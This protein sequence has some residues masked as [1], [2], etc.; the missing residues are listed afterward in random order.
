MTIDDD[1]APPPGAE[2]EE[3]FIGARPGTP[4]GSPFSH[5]RILSFVCS[6]LLLAAQRGVLCAAER[7]SV[8]PCDRNGLS[9]RSRS[10]RALRPAPGQHLSVGRPVPP[11][12][13][14][15]GRGQPWFNVCSLLEERG[16]CAPTRALTRALP[17][18]PPRRAH[19]P[20]S[21]R[22]SARQTGV[23]E[24]R[25]TASKSPQQMTHEHTD[26]L[27]PLFERP[28]RRSNSTA[29]SRSTTGASPSSTAGRRTPR[30]PLLSPRARAHRSRR[31]RSLPST[32]ASGS[33]RA[34]FLRITPPSVSHASIS[35][36]RDSH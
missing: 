21:A 13:V 4:A 19:A 35:V 6:G 17:G 26:S 32:R 15:V 12:T 2:G 8:H 11:D 5:A 28:C 34:L 18:A 7:S 9:R 27:L 25:V 23:E 10:S 1:N 3:D 30:T 14:P 29:G 20:R 31:R 16:G 36:L 22:P 33:A 24:S